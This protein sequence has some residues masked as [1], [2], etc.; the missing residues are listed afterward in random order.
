[1]P[2]TT[3]SVSSHESRSRCCDPTWN[4]MPAAIPASG[5]QRRADGARRRLAAEL[6]RQRPVGAAAVVTEADADG[7][8]GRDVGDLV[9]LGDRV[10][11]VARDAAGGGVR[12][13][14]ALLDR[15]AVGDVRRVGAGEQAAV[16]LC[17]AGDVERRPE[18]RRGARGSAGRGSPSRRRTPAPTAS[19]RRAA[20]SAARRG[21]RRRRRTVSARRRRAGTRRSSAEAGDGCEGASR[22]VTVGTIRIEFRRRELLLPSVSGPVLVSQSA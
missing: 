22:S 3:W 15:V 4:E 16:D 2:A 14:A 9:E 17:R 8:A 5:R 12:D 19:P 13:V 7:C 10:D 21:R 18:A 11:G 20:R 1:M 6:A